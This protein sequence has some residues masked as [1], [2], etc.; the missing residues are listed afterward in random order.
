[1]PSLKGKIQSV[2]GSKR[3]EFCPFIAFGFFV[4]IALSFVVVSCN[5][6]QVS[7]QNGPK[8]DVVF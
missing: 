6:I 5:A 3:C 1:M 4:Q 2:R 7:L 8:L